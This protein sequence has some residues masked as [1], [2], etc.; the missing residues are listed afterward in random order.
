VANKSRV[1]V[2][3]NSLPPLSAEK[4]RMSA[5]L[6]KAA[7]PFF[8]EL[9]AKL[10]G[11]GGASRTHEEAV[12]LAAHG[13]YQV[14]ALSKYLEEHGSTYEQVTMHGSSWKA[15][16]EFAQCSEASRRTVMLL[17]ALGLTPAARTKIK[18]GGQQSGKAG[19]GEFADL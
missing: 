18:T 2:G 17:T 16:P 15:R 11:S 12:N 10:E 6:P 9:V 3:V 4:P 13:M 8:E 7:A 19:A 14:A 1:N 5:W